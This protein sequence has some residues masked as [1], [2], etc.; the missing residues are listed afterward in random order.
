MDPMFD[1]F[2]IDRIRHEERRRRER[3]QPRLDVPVPDEP[4]ESSEPETDR[5]NAEARGVVIIDRDDEF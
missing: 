1:A 4:P 2:I 5:G 3:D